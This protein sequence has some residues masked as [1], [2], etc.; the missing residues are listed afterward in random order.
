MSV[1]VTA[2]KESYMRYSD[3]DIVI[4]VIDLAVAFAEGELRRAES[5][6]ASAI[7]QYRL[8]VVAH[9]AAASAEDPA[10]SSIHGLLTPMAVGVR[11]QR[12]LLEEAEEKLKRLESVRDR[13]SSDSKYRAALA[14]DMDI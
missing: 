10:A 7:E 13:A 11:R 14:R 1:S 12:T 2:I 4:S 3:E 5:D 9:E 8:Q 6:L